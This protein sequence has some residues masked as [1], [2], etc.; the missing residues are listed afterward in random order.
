MRYRTKTALGIE[1][2]E[3]R[4]RFA[5]VEKSEQGIRV[6]ASVAGE[7]PDAG[8]PKRRA[9][10]LSQVFRR[11]DRRTRRRGMKAAVAVSASPIVMQLLDMPKPVPTNV[12]EFVQQEL[13]QY[14]ALSGR[15]ILSDFCGI[16]AGA[17]PRKRLLAAAVDRAQLREV[18]K[19]CDSTRTVIEAVEPAILAYTRALVE[20]QRQSWH[21]RSVLIAMLASRNLTIGVLRNGALD[22]IRVRECPAELDGP[23]PL[24]TWLAEELRAVI[25][26]YE[27]EG[28]LNDREWWTRV[29]IQ[30]GRHTASE[31]SPLLS[32]E[33]GTESAI[34]VD[35]YEPLAAHAA[36]S[37]GPS[38]VAVGAAL[39]LL[40]AEADDFRINLLPEE[41]TQARSASRRLLIGANVAALV[42][43][44]LFLATQFLTRTAGAMYREI[45]QA[46]LSRQFYTAPALIVQE[47]HL[48]REIARVKQQFGRYQG[49]LTSHDVDW[50]DV[51]STLGKATP[52][53]VCITQM[54]CEDNRHLSLKGLAASYDAAR[55]LVRNLSGR[56]PFE[57]V[58]LARVQRQPNDTGLMEYQI[59]C[60]L[61]PGN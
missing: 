36:T 21:S 27:S 52:A 38:R 26:Y 39:K 30:E 58:S 28:S 59:N 16:G 41:V 3:R 57:E 53:D 40:E 46:R 54:A 8:L 44:G 2:G 60:S 45:E 35:P 13:K 11:L 6:L 24:C 1:I 25:R 17:A 22:F 31:I 56:G 20:S 34:V 55:A 48:D 4:V 14:V 43:L 5:L 12:S 51:L 18:V 23:G 9:T 61:R 47:Q 10:A 42:L 29:V 19:T 33:A 7:L 32:A 15:Q 50:A 37:E 49:V